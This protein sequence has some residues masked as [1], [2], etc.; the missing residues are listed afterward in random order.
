[1]FYKVILIEK[2][3]RRWEEEEEKWREKIIFPNSME[4]LI[5]VTFFILFEKISF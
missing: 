5:L 3:Q 2:R 4:K 1:M